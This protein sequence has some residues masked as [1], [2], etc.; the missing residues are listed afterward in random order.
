MRLGEKELFMDYTEKKIKPY[1]TMDRVEFNNACR[2]ISMNKNYHPT[3]IFEKIIAVKEEYG[4]DMDQ[5]D[6]T[7]PVL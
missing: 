1:D 2:N 6:E 7:E 5:D 4:V 3:N